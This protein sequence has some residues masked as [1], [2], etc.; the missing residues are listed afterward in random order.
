MTPTLAPS[1]ARLRPG[2]R[3]RAKALFA[4]MAVVFS[5][6]TPGEELADP[7]VDN[8][9]ARE[10]LFLRCAARDAN[11]GDV[12]VPA[13]DEDTHALDFYQAIGGLGTPVTIFTFA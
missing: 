9:L 8:L 10:D 3:A 2:D 12:F 6:D 5:E 7:Y 1:L 4:V 11:H 13:D